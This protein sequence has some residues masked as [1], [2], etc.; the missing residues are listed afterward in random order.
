MFKN[1]DIKKIIYHNNV[2]DVD[3]VKKSNDYDKNNI[4]RSKL[5]NE[6]SVSQEFDDEYG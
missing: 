5:A 1:N 6:I 3:T 4:P 2:Y